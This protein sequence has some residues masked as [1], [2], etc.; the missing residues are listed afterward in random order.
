MILDRIALRRS[1]LLCKQAISSSRDEGIK[2]PPKGG[3]VYCLIASLFCLSGSAVCSALCSLCTLI[4]DKYIASQDNMN[5][6]S[7]FK[8]V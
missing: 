1:G 5:A 4:C 3:V 7:R 2:L 6:V 8:R